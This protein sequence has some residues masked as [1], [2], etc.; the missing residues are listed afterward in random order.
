MAAGE[1]SGLWSGGI[2]ANSAGLGVAGTAEAGAE[3]G[4]GYSG[5][6]KIYVESPAFATAG[7]DRMMES[8]AGGGGTTVAITAEMVVGTAVISEYNGSAT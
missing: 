6:M 4:A 5:L 3:L 8:Q 7:T 2:G 1:A